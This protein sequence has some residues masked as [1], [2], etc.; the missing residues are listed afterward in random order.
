MP[1]A[2]SAGRKAGEAVVP[3]PLCRWDPTQPAGI[4][5]QMLG[6]LSRVWLSLN[7]FYRFLSSPFSGLTHFDRVRVTCMLMLAEE[8]NLLLMEE[9]RRLGGHYSGAARTGDGPVLDLLM[10][11][12][13]KCSY[14]CH[15]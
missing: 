6:S 2:V 5:A 7:N 8:A 15:C 3:Y 1:I 14:F 10:P 9:D 12:L 4:A 13:P 11:C